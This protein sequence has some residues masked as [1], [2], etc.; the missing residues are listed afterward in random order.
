MNDCTEI[1]RL[2]WTE[3]PE[4]VPGAHIAGCAD[5]REQTRQVADLQAALAGLR[6]RVAPVPDHL[7]ASIVTAMSRT[8]LDR[9]RVIVSHPRFWKGAA[10]GA[11][12]A[13]T[14]VAGVLVARRIARGTEPTGDLSPEPSLVA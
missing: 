13:A 5:C 4:A 9:A 6:T 14:A 2:A 11:A 3:G 12:A 10:V 8:R 7:H 1:Q